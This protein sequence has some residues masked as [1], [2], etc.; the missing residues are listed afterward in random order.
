MGCWRRNRIRLESQG[1]KNSSDVEKKTTKD[2]IPNAE[3][4]NYHSRIPH[5]PIRPQDEQESEFLRLHSHHSMYF[6]LISDSGAILD[7]TG[8]TY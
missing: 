6:T 3:W 5:A 2:T 7:P 8:V 1:P 4:I